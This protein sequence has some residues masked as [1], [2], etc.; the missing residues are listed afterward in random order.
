MA[1]AGVH[2]VSP[3]G[4]AAWS[5]ST[6][7]ST[8]CSWQAAIANAHAGD[9]VYFREGIYEPGTVANYE[10]PGMNPANSGEAGSSITFQAYPGETA[11]IHDAI[12]GPAIGANR[13][14]YIVWDGFTI[15]RNL[16][17]GIG[18][19]TAVRIDNRSSNIIVRNNN[20]IGRPQKDQYNGSLMQIDHG[21]HDIFVYN[22]RLHGKSADPNPI[23]SV[24]NASAVWVMEADHVYIYNNDIYDNNNGL[25]TKSEP[26]YLY[27]YNN[28]LWNNTR[29]AFNLLP[30]GRNFS[31]DIVIYQNVVRNSPSVVS[32]PDAAQLW[33]LRF[34][35]NTAYNS[36]DASGIVLGNGT[37]DN[38]R[39]AEVFNNVFCFGGAGSTWERVGSG[40]DKPLYVDFNNFYVGGRWG[41][42]DSYS[43]PY[44]SSI[45]GWRAA[46]G[47]DLDSITSNPLLVNPGG[48]TPEEYKLMNGSPAIG[49]GIDRQDFDG[50]GDTSERINVGAYIT[51]DEVIGYRAPTTGCAAP[52]VTTQ[53][54][55]QLISSGQTASLSVSASGTSPLSYQWY[56]GASGDVSTP[57]ADATSADYTTPPLTAATDYWVRVTNACG[58][59]DSQAANITVQGS[60]GAAPTI[61][62]I[63][64][65]TPAPGGSARINGTGFSASPTKNIVLFGAARA[66]VRKAAPGVL[67]VVIPRSLR[68]CTTVDVTVVVNG[69]ASNRKSLKLRCARE[70]RW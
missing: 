46:S 62:G 57:I 70:I 29:A 2:Y 47:F 5:S 55:G 32:S 10:T 58:T 38:S 9:I 37:Y 64:S 11:V 54:Q 20:I 31:R 26:N 69:T 59:V 49:A 44:Y 28:H 40:E 39:N 30:Q 67:R 6:D 43:V 19:S 7:I 16:D 45:E 68:R 36:A 53:P 1:A 60:P 3:T 15:D 52:V 24:M 66:K 23:A 18:A 14:S 4:D 12:G 42:G 35:N 34:H 50:D 13:R 65:R 41:M 33:N 25:S 63:V 17:S 21:S 51:G 61:L 56:L 27:F 48:A 8:P 22:N